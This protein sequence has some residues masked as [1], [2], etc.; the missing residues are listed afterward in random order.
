[1]RRLK[2]LHV[3]IDENLGGIETYLLKISS[4][5]DFQNFHFDFLSFKGS[6]PCFMRELS[7][8]GCGFKFITG[9]RE[10]YFRSRKEL[11]E[12]LEAEKYDIIHCHLNS[13]SYIDPA[14]V[15][16]KVGSKVIVHSRNA[17]SATGSSNRYLCFINKFLLPYDKV[18][19][20]AVSDKAG[21][22]MFGEN[23]KCLVLNNGVDTD[24]FRFSE[25][26]RNEFRKELGISDDREIIVH[27]GAFRPQKN[28][29]F[30]IDVFSC[31]QKAHK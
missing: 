28:H 18:V 3:G 24:K 13:L 23:R 6:H 11:R 29:S 14:L 26:K 15:G 4:H 31:Y 17:G 30:L 19:K 7:S 10:N 9:R 21:K 16:L 2:I 8:L 1:M 20:V 12:L 27:V 25:V 22:W 5:F